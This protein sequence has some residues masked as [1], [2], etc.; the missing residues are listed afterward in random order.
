MS[1]SDALLDPIK[2]NMNALTNFLVERMQ[3][4]SFAVREAAGETVGR[5]A[6]N[7]SNDF[8]DLHQ[9]IMPC[10]LKVV[11]DLTASKEEL[12][13]QKALYA[14][15]EFV[16]NLEYDIR[17]YLEDCLQALLAYINGN[18]ARDIKYWALV[19]LSNTIT[20]A[21]KRIEPY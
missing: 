1:D 11:R 4:T 20:T 21:N 5:F 19:A 12:T 13:I 10:L 8:L 9:K 6:E 2:E 15:N 18:Y 17:I 14:L 16:Q 3:D 7:C